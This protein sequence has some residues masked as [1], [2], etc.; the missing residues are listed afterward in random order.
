MCQQNVTIPHNKSNKK[1]RKESKYRA[2]KGINQ[3]INRTIAVTK[4]N[5]TKYGTVEKQEKEQCTLL[6]LEV[7]NGIY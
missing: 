2:L 7:K 5:K 4:Q 3:L 1:R 6:T